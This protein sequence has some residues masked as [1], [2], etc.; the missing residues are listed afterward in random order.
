MCGGVVEGEKLLMRFVKLVGSPGQRQLV[1]IQAPLDVKVCFHQVLVALARG[2]HNGL[3]VNAQPAT[4]ALKG[5]RDERPAAVGNQ[6]D[7]DAIALTRGIEHRQGHPACLGGGHGARQ[8][9]ARIAVKDDQAPPAVPLQGKIHHPAVDKPILVRRSRFEGMRLGRGGRGVEACG[10]WDI[11]IDLAVERHDA[12]DGAH[13]QIC[14]AAQTPDPKAPGIRMALLQ[15][16]D[17]HHGWQP[18]LARWGIRRP[19]LVRDA[20]QV[21]ASKR[22]IHRLI[23]GRETCKN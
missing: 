15:M 20:G 6:M 18:R 19:A 21:V 8:H 14:F 11:R 12:F 7:G 1:V 13:G 23:V 10:P 22:A 5:V 9:G 2:T 17:F 16:I 3:M 4:D